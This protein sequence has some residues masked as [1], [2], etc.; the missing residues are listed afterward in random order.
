MKK[1]LLTIMLAV[2][3]ALCFTVCFVAC[4]E[5]TPPAPD[6]TYT[7]TVEQSENGS[8]T[9][10]ATTVKQGGSV[11]LTI[12]PDSGY[13]LD[14]LTVN[15][16]A[17]AV[18]GNTYTVTDVRA[19]VTVGATFKLQSPVEQKVTVTF[20]NATPS[21][22]Q[23]T[24][25][26][27][28]GELPTV[29][30]TPGNRFVGWFT[31]ETGG[32]QVTAETIV[33][34][35]AD[36]TLY[37][38]FTDKLIVTFD[39][40]LGSGRELTREVSQDN[41]IGDLPDAQAPANSALLGWYVDDAAIDA[42]YVV[43]GDVTVKASYITAAI[44]LKA[45]SAVSAIGGLTSGN[46]T[47]ELEVTVTV[48]G[49]PS[50]LAVTLET[51]DPA[52]ATIAENKVTAL[53]D[54][55]VQ[56]KAMYN[57]AEVS[58]TEFYIVCRNYSEY[59]EVSDKAGLMAIKSD[60]AGKYVLTAD[61]DLGGDGLWDASNDYAPLFGAFTGVLDGMG[62]KVYNGIAHPSGWNKGAFM[63]VK[64]TV[65][66]IAFTQLHTEAKTTYDNGFFGSVQ[67][68]VENVFLQIDYR[69]TGRGGGDGYGA[70]AYALTEGGTIK[71]CVVDFTA[72]KEAATDLV[73]GIAVNAA[74]WLGKADNCFIIK[75]NN[76]LASGFD[77]LYFKEAAPGVATG[78][79]TN[80]GAFDYLAQLVNSKT[81]DVNK[82]G[83]AWGVKEGALYFYGNKVM[84]ATPEYVINTMGDEEVVFEDLVAE[85]KA[86]RI[87]NI[88]FIHNGEAMT[89]VPEGVQVESTD[90]AVAELVYD[91][92]LF[93]F[94]LNS[95]K[96]GVTTI[97][98]S[99]GDYHES[100]TLTLTQI[101]HIKTAEEFKTKIAAN[102]SGTFLLDNDIDFEGEILTQAIVADFTGTLDGQNHAVKNLVLSGGANGGLFTTLHGTVKNIA[103]VNINSS[104]TSNVGGLF[105]NLW[106]NTFIENVY[107]DYVMNADG[108]D[109]E[110]AGPLG[111][112]ITVAEVKNVLIN[113][114]FADTVDVK[115]IAGIGAIIGQA[116]AWASEVS[117]VKII[118]NGIA[119]NR[120]ELA[121]IEAAPGIYALWSDCKQFE[122]YGA[123]YASADGKATFTTDMGWK[124]ENT[125]ITFGTTKVLAVPE[126]TILPE[127]TRVTAE[128][129]DGMEPFTLNV[130]V[131]NYLETLT[132]YPD[133]MTVE[134]SEETVA[135]V[136][137][138]DGKITVTALTTGETVI[139]VAIGGIS[140][141]ITVV[142]A[143][144]AEADLVYTGATELS[145]DYE[146]AGELKAIAITA[147]KNEE[148]ADIPAS[149]AFTT[150]NAAVASFVYND[151]TKLIQIRLDGAGTATLTAQIGAGT[152]VSVEVTVE[153]IFHISTAQEF[154]DKIQANYSGHFVIDKDIDLST[155]QSG[156]LYVGNW[157]PICGHPNVFNGIIDGQGHSISNGKVLDGWNGGF[158]YDFQGT[159]KNI[160][161]INLTMP[162]DGQF[163]GLFEL[164]TNGAIIENVYIDWVVSKL[165]GNSVVGALAGQVAAA[166]INNLIIN[167][168]LANGIEPADVREF[169]GVADELINNMAKV[170]NV[171]VYATWVTGDTVSVFKTN[172][173]TDA[174]LNN[175]T[176]HKNF[177]DLLASDLTA[178]TAENGWTIDATGITFG[179]NRVLEITA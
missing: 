83:S 26:Q 178:F 160:A 21:S 73:G 161:F 71:N 53:A 3:A 51:T 22:K 29:I 11:T 90:P 152:L 63:S 89:G 88:S 48:D 113:L 37:P 111:G 176:G 100:F 58:R 119:A 17:V 173:T 127:K 77:G 31:A 112:K 150:T 79:T 32:T 145:L 5:Q 78:I 6:A 99:V 40:G 20:Q 12:A 105:V 171:K 67:G 137:I 155:Y 118:V 57:G 64:G 128:Y 126:Y 80:S 82:L 74:N 107:I 38:H 124:F 172:K 166:T 43:T 141:E 52:I 93:V 47:P 55:S 154:I 2:I 4:G 42:S 131:L 164:V 60:V 158:I 103:F 59:T 13:E 143:L 163:G 130:T 115:T 46:T 65:R 62:H 110:K 8:V 23:V 117:N 116:N 72:T 36:H 162:G 84:D 165:P 61:I 7:V 146:T 140:A 96:A 125:G 147:Q 104:A 136:A 50:E 170:N 122:G 156:W 109:K 102:P 135:T 138:D 167:L 95:K 149:V 41:A 69:Y 28:Y 114:R 9:A 132:A 27:A 92:D 142:L 86:Q 35:T 87:Y 169:G 177:V 123:F 54:G 139:T 76:S 134:S 81:V 24:V 70:L 75:N 179:K 121:A 159:L 44:A 174:T 68:T 98:V 157:A 168:R 14:A 1:K 34:A 16:S 153:Q 30:G 120:L 97:T 151:E 56:V 15:G 148:A 25:G 49:E 144:P 18:T 33:T 10:S 108:D 45:D 91:E 19:N 85:D 101:M 129:T 133:T 175:C 39:F 66:D 106:K 94:V